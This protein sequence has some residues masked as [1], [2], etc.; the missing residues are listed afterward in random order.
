MPLCPWPAFCPLLHNSLYTLNQPP[1]TACLKRVA[2]MYK[3]RFR[4][5]TIKPEA[6]AFFF[7]LQSQQQQQKLSNDDHLQ[8]VSV[9]QVFFLVCGWMLFDFTSFSPPGPSLLLEHRRGSLSPTPTAQLWRQIPTPSF[10][11]NA[12]L[13]LCSTR[14][15]RYDL[16]NS[17]TTTTAKVL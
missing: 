1:S 13:T 14:S 12:R 9:P 5:I 16:A 3:S 8:R 7:G 17:S 10:T 6:R 11:S 2:N 4:S 15:G